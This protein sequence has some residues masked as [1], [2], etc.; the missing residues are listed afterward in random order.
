[1]TT[2][3][4]EST[5]TT[6]TSKRA[7]WTGR[8]LSTLAVL[9]LLIDGIMKLF[10]PAFVT[11]AMTKL[12]YPPSETVPIGIAVLVCTIFYVIPRTSVFGAVLLT[13]FLGGAVA[14][15]FRVQSPLF[16]NEL[17]PVYVAALV[18]GGLLLRDAKL[19]DLFPVRK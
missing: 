1:M 8:I 2:T 11:D 10:K 4:T 16:S 15:N 6:P 14:T 19:R 3:T 17:F 13:G 7:V 5:V 18:W 9:F 12:G